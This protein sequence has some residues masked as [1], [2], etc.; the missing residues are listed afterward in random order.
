MH[1]ALV[2]IHY[3]LQVDGL[4]HVVG[5]GCILVERLVDLD[6]LLDAGLGADY[7]RCEDATGEIA[8]I[9]NEVDVYLQ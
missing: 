5:E 3:L 4:V 2:G 7:L 8:A 9:G 6:D 1:Q